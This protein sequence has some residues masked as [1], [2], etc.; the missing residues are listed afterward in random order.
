MILPNIIGKTF[1][2]KKIMLSK[3][4]VRKMQGKVLRISGFPPSS[5]GPRETVEV[6]R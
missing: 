1:Q 3:E 6:E 5:E 2:E 4:L